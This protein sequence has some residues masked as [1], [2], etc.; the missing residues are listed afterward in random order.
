MQIYAMHILNINVK[1]GM[2]ISISI[3]VRVPHNVVCIPDI[4]VD[5]EGKASDLTRKWM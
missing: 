4:V 1:S 3:I 5:V 2:E